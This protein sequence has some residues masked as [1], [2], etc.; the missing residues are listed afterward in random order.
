MKILALD[1]A[2]VTTGW[3]IFDKKKLVNSG[4][5]TVKKTLPIEV[6]LHQIQQNILD[7]I[8]NN[9][10]DDN[11]DMIIF[12]GIQ[13]QSNVETFRK[14]AMVQAAIL[15]LCYNL[16]IKYV[17]YSPSEWRAINGGGYGRK[18]EEQKNAAIIKAKEWYQVDVDSDIADAINI[19]HAYLINRTND[20]SNAAFGKWTTNH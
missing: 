20:K 18:R 3:A 14:L 1:Q 4:S 10:G 13:Q 16:D 7:V 17:I 12:E 11:P 2:A 19:G 5:F 9:F 6:R 8:Y 15:L